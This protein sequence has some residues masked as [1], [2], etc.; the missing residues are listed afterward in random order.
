MKITLSG[1][2]KMGRE[3][4]QIAR[5]KNHSI[6]AILDQKSDWDTYQKAIVDS[7][8][9]IDFSEPNVVVANIKK[10]FDMNIPIVVGTTGWDNEKEAI[11][12]LCDTKKQAIFTASNFSIGVNIFFEV[13]TLLAKF[14][15]QYPQYHPSIEEIHHT[16]KLD[17]P[18]GTAIELA[19]QM[20]EQINRKAKYTLDHEIEPTDLK[21]TS[22]RI[23]DV[24]GTHIVTYS[25]DVDQIELKHTAHSR[26]GFASGAVM[27]AEWLVSKKGC[28]GIK[29]LLGIS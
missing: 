15:N 16:Q 5:Q 7:D 13:N 20:L 11:F 22:K 28:F 6:S 21:I 29:D 9:I 26:K 3:I 25:S 4:E 12:Q 10:A 23:E 19:K 24:P 1:Y 18:S 2:G 14:M 27:A 8:V 17:K